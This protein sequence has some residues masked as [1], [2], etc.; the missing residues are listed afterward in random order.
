MEKVVDWDG[1]ITLGLISNMANFQRQKNRPLSH[2]TLFLAIGKKKFKIL[3]SGFI[4]Y[5]YETLL[6]NYAFSVILP[7]IST[8]DPFGLTAT[9]IIVGPWIPFYFNNISNGNRLHSPQYNQEDFAKNSTFATDWYQIF[10]IIYCFKTKQCNLP[11]CPPLLVALDS[12]RI[13]SLTCQIFK[14]LFLKD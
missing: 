6:Y 7:C 5:F 14:V 4:L 3:A 9:T 13:L 10:S 11:L 12:L 2:F 1:Q 8:R